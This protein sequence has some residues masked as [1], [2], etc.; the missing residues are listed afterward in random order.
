MG[1]DARPVAVL[2]GAVVS[3]WDV[4]VAVAVVT[5]GEAD[6]IDDSW[7]SCLILRAE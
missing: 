2:A 5:E 6:V 7:Q 3:A 4:A 1:E